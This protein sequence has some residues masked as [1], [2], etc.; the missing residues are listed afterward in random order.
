MPKLSAVPL[1]LQ[2]CYEDSRVQ[3]A[4]QRRP[5]APF[6]EGYEVAQGDWSLLDDVRDRP[7]LYRSDSE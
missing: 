2:A 6:P 1:L 5:G 7:P 3:S 4:Y